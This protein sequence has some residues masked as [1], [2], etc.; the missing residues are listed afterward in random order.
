MSRM[1]IAPMIW[2]LS[3]NYLSVNHFHLLV[4]LYKLTF[5][6]PLHLVQT[7]LIADLS[8]FYLLAKIVNQLCHTLNNCYNSFGHWLTL[9]TLLFRF[10]SLLLC[11]IVVFPHK[12]YSLF[13]LL[14][15]HAFQTLVTN[16]KYQ[17]LNWPH[18]LVYYES[19]CNFWENHPDSSAPS[20]FCSTHPEKAR[21]VTISTH[22]VRLG[23]TWTLDLASCHNIA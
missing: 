23:G 12:A 1:Q 7:C 8:K 20:V 5:Y 2:F 9:C 14:F 18:G 10:I 11:F 3:P 19:F 16:Y 22:V 21:S 17:R 15:L 13:V 6:T 4:V